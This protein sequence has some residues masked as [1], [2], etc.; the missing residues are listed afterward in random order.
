MA[1]LTQPNISAGD[2]LS[3]TVFLAIALHVF[4]VLTDFINEDPAPSAKTMEITL[5]RFKDEKAP[6]EAD[7]LA[8]TNQQGAGTLE[9]KAQLSSPTKS[10]DES[11]LIQ[12]SSAP[13]KTQDVE[14]RA[15]EA[16]V[17]TL[18]SENSVNAKHV[19]ELNFF[20]QEETQQVRSLI[21]RSLQ[22]AEL[23]ASLDNQL[24]QYARQPNVTR[25]TAASTMQAN[26]AR[27]VEQVVSKI[28]RVGKQFF[29]SDGNRKLYGKPRVLIGIYA[30]G[31][32]RDVRIM[33]SSGNLVLDA[34]TMNIVA[35]AA[36]FAPFPKQV[37]K[38]R[39]VLELI[40]TFNY[41][42]SGVSSF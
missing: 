5:S 38:E 22:I 17:V 31:S 28:E 8:A 29:P 24:Q 3:F 1:S 41:S 13:A 42:R 15:E 14:Q 26:D 2:R 12:E 39:D 36:P 6:D 33:Q 18:A 34:K 32:L 4:I 16:R 9:E 11:M 20:V 27:Y 40:R 10:I 30:D 21:E 19:D 37:R 23:E 25:L 7:F 35:R